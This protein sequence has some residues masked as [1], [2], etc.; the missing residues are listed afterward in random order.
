M[1]KTLFAIFAV[2]LALLFVGCSERVFDYDFI[3]VPPEGGGSTGNTPTVNPDRIIY[4][5]TTDGNKIKNPEGITT[6]ESN[7]YEKGVGM[8]RYNRAVASIPDNAFGGFSTLKTIKLPASVE[9]IGI[10][11]FNGCASLTSVNIPEKVISIGGYAFSGCASLASITIPENVTS[12][13]GSAFNGC[14]SLSSI[15]IPEKVT[16]IGD[17]AF[18]NCS[19]ELIINSKIIETD[20]SNAASSPRK[21]LNGSKISKVIIGDGVKKIGNMAFNYCSSLTDITIS[22]SVVLIDEK[23]F[24][25]CTSLTD[26]TI[27]DSVISIGESAFL[28]CSKLVKVNISNLAAWCRIIWGDTNSNPLSKGADL[29]LNGKKLTELTIP[30]EIT[31]VKSYAFYRY[32]SLTSVIIPDSVTSIGNHAFYNCSGLTSATIGNGVTSIGNY[33]F[34]GCSGLASATICNS[35]TSIGDAAFRGCSA[36]AEIY[37]KP[38]TPP[39]LGGTA[40]FD[41]GPSKRKIYVPAGSTEAYKTATNWSEYADQIVADPS[42]S[43]A[44]T[45]QYFIE[46]TSTDG[47]VV[48]P[49]AEDFGANLISNVYE[50][51]KGRI[52]FDAPISRIANSTFQNCTT[53]T[54]IT[55]PSSVSSIGDYAFSG[56]KYLE[57]VNLPL[58]LYEIG[59]YAFQNCSKIKEMNIPDSVCDIGSSAF[60]NC[61]SIHTITIGSGITS[62]GSDAFYNCTG[63]LVINSN[64]PASP[65]T[66]TSTFSGSKFARVTFGA[67]VKTIGQYAFNK[68]TTLL[69]VNLSTGLTQIDNAAFSGCT[70]LE[71]VNVPDMLTWC[72]IAFGNI[73]SNPIYNGAKLCIDG[74]V[75]TSICIPSE[76]TQISSYAF[77]KCASIEEV[78]IGEN[79]T[80]IGQSAFYNCS[81]LQRVIIS[82]LS[83]W[84]KITFGSGANPL[85]NGADLYL[86]SECVTTLIVP[87][88]ITEIKG[89]A[90]YKCSSITKVVLPENVT[91]I[92]VRAFSACAALT[93]I[94]IPSKVTSIGENAFY[95][96][97][98]LAEIHCEAI[99]PPILGNSNVF[100]S[101]P[102]E[103]KIYVPAGATE[104]YKT[105]TNWSE[106]ADQIVADPTAAPSTTDYY[107]EY[108]STDRAVV[109]PYAED[110]GAN[111]ISNVYENGKGRIYF[112]GAIAKIGENAFRNC[113][114][115][116]GITIP[117]SVTECG[118]NAFYSCSSISRVDISDLKAWCKI[119]FTAMP[120]NPLYPGTA[121]LY[122]NGVELTDLTIPSDITEIKEYTFCRC[123]SLTNVTIHDKVISIGSAAFG[124]C[125]SISR[126]NITDLSAWCRIDFGS[127]TSNPLCFGTLYVNGVGITNL[128]IPSDITEIKTYAFYKCSSLISVT[129]HDKVTSIGPSAF[130]DCPL[131]TELYCKPT[132]PPALGGASVFD[133]G[134]S[135]RKIYVPSGSVETYKTATN[136]SE[137][138][139]QIVADPTPSN[140][141]S[142]VENASCDLN[143]KMIWVEGGMFTMGATA[144]QG[145]DSYDDEKPTHIVTID[146]YYIAECEVTQAQWKK[147]MGRTISEQRDL[148]GTSSS[149]Y[150][151]GDDYPVYYVNYDDAKEFCTK[152][153]QLTGKTYSLPT[154][155][156]WEY[157]ARGG[158]KSKGYKYSGSSTIGSVSWYS[159]NAGSTA[160]PIKQ[161][162]PNELGLYDMSG[163]IYEWCSDW[164]GSYTSASQTNPTGVSSGTYRVMRGGS[165][166]HAQ[167]SSRVSDRGSYIPSTRGL[168]AGLRIVCTE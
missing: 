1:R 104:A 128:T 166:Q 99:T 116:S 41:N 29:Y 32:E 87:D 33:A 121:K 136:W 69:E 84:C 126:V 44:S 82:D 45:T 35:V 145:S 158:N 134:A 13:G 148:R 25:T 27:G 65:S 165:W 118:K 77:Y 86:G 20:F 81:S 146:S 79:V 151:V 39:T 90:F 18:Y 143:M 114:T 22:N 135:T 130:Y 106:Y 147:I 139:S 168:D 89:Y 3:N 123:A 101:G 92:G 119:N 131:L 127:G 36:L 164:F 160:H 115:L 91:T 155:A 98:A 117:S 19:G 88:D 72:R 62:I 96:C 85:Y 124:N 21:W 120:S 150:G 17:S 37:C 70:S 56:C 111:L 31:E 28:A 142:Y 49:Y 53:L 50:N 122:L 113:S 144:E 4:Y 12:I 23:A 14:T 75:V 55:I 2:L 78:I 83:A 80:S 8:L 133:N 66:D 59:N 154:E 52:Y 156:Q 138:A 152:L 157:A 161:K 129:I 94:N 149:L 102:A 9:A 58:S 24:S 57:E 105:A 167:T 125:E 107:I 162:Q 141:A 159:G 11:A 60:Y 132:T 16:S 51:N 74:S 137:Y 42:S 34:Y 48:T 67:N 5:T 95:D 10:N 47:G 140:V 110:F 71:V 103:R 108:T 63:E 93:N 15:T 46:Y 76:I 54:T 153:S 109:T 64:I 30:S 100:D 43:G 40:V 38:T 7:T 97:L 26:V 6:L 163:N 112:D 61:R 73:A 68:C